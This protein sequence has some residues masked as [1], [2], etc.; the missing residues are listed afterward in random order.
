MAYWFSPARRLKKE[1]SVWI[2]INSLF[3]KG[4]VTAEPCS[5]ERRIL[6]EIIVK[7]N[8]EE[9]A[10]FAQLL[11]KARRAGEI[12]MFET[13]RTMHKIESTTHAVG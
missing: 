9:K 2:I 7:L 5:A 11:G 12:D 4:A 3:K 8:S 10:M 13:I 6:G 1:C